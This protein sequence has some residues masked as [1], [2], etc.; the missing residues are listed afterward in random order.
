MVISSTRASQ[1][2]PVRQQQPP[3]ASLQLQRLG[4]VEAAPGHALGQHLSSGAVENL[5]KNLG[6]HLGKSIRSKPYR[7]NPPQIYGF[8]FF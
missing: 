2:V 1:P 4:G 3:L 7:S 6:K 8:N 5:G